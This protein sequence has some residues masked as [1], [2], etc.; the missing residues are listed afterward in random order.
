MQLLTRGLT[1]EFKKSTS[2]KT[3]T[4]KKAREKEREQMR[5]ETQREREIYGGR[6]KSARERKRARTQHREKELERDK[7]YKA[8]QHIEQWEKAGTEPKNRGKLKKRG[9]KR[10]GEMRS[11]VI[12]FCLYLFSK[13]KQAGRHIQ[14]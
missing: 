6:E 12:V 2:R 1:T 9:D 4:E 7:Y 8:E 11:N 10:E 5:D 13:K 3:I 14:S